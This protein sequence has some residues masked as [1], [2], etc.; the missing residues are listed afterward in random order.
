[1]TDLSKLKYLTANCK[2]VS[3]RGKPQKGQRLTTT[4]AGAQSGRSMVAAA[5]YA[6]GVRLHDTRL[7]RVHDFRAKSGVFTSFIVG[8][9]GWTG[10]TD[11]AGLWNMAELAEKRVDATTG[12]EWIFALPHE[13]THAQR[14]DLLRNIAH[15]LAAKYGV[16]VDASLHIPNKEGDQRNH[17]A[18]VLMTSR[19][20]NPDGTLGAKTRE[21]DGKGGEIAAFRLQLEDIVNTAMIAAGRPE[22][23]SYR[24]KAELGIDEPVQVHE[25]VNAT[26]ARRRNYR[27]DAEHAGQETQHQ[28]NA[29]AGFT[30]APADHALLRSLRE[31]IAANDSELARMAANPVTIPRPAKP[32][33]FSRGRLKAV[34]R[35]DRFLVRVAAAI[36]ERYGHILPLPRVF[37]LAA[38]TIEA[39]TKQAQRA[40]A[41]REHN[42]AL[43]AQAKGVLARMLKE[44]GGGA[45]QGSSTGRPKKKVYGRK[46]AAKNDLPPAIAA[47][48][49][50]KNAQRTRPQQK[51]PPQPAQ[52]AA[53]RTRPQKARFIKM[54]T[55]RTRTEQP[56]NPRH[57]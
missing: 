36:A 38:A 37:M 43:R 24:S 1:M 16:I 26:N 34:K 28:I 48:V 29:K 23:V 54:H 22:R 33:R 19:R 35:E 3:R 30:A 51:R 53:K 2:A 40:A 10:S 12:R 32:L 41:I 15:A 44:Q 52:Y 47:E 46:P 21:L 45:G 6:A 49:V 7:G 13:L 42:R 55:A 20:V 25:G 39:S 8:A 57:S 17:H 31:Q 50:R 18:H 14:V 11:R 9:G 56:K 5:A 27:T 4:K